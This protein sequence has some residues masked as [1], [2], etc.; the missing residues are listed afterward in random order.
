M[1]KEVGHEEQKEVT[2]IDVGALIGN[3]VTSVGLIVNPHKGDGP[4]HTPEASQ[5]GKDVGISNDP[6]IGLDGGTGRNEID[7]RKGNA[8][9]NGP[10][11]TNRNGKKDNPHNTGKDTARQECEGSPDA[12]HDDDENK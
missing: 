2:V 10:G 6:P 12:R 7:R 4:R 1:R 9:P 8:A 5:C 3:I 11:V